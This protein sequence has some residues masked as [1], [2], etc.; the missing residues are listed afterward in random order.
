MKRLKLFLAT[1]AVCV[2]LAPVGSGAVLAAEKNVFDQVPC[3]KAGGSA[4]CSAGGNPITGPDGALTRVT[5]VVAYLA[6]ITAIILL[7]VSGFMYIT[8]SGDSQ[9]ISAAKNTIIY[10]LIGLLI[11]V[12]A[13]GII[14]FI[15]NK[16]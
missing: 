6:G 1:L 4:A 8:A 16:V 3:E 9:K 15:L 13:Q 7:I 10:A 11:V 5:Q 12:F 2:C 14:I